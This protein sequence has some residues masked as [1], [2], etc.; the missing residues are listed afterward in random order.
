MIALG[1]LFNTSA[2]H[3][4]FA[5]TDYTQ[6]KVFIFE[7]DSIVWEHAA[8]NSNDLWVL[9][10]GNILFTTGKGVLEMTRKND[11]VFR[12]ESS[13]E[14]YACQ[15]LKNGNTFIG[16]CNNG[17]LLEISPSGKI[18]FQLKILPDSMK[19]GGHGFMRNA[20]K[21][22]NG[23]YLVTL[24][25]QKVVREYTPKGKVVWEVKAP[26]GPH[27]VV[28]LPNGNTLVS[29]GDATKDPH[30]C[31]FDKDGNLVWD[32]SNA[33]LP[34]QPFRFLGGM[35]RFPNG[36]TLV[37]NWLGHK[38]FGMAPHII[39]LTPDKKIVWTFGGHPRIKTISSFVD[40]DVPA[41]PLKAEVL[42]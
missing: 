6:G 26:G 28:R 39:E 18:V 11:T 8:P 35:Q 1:F 27:S 9:P 19:T 15:R 7:K 4:S 12:Y 34:G 32:V 38:Q 40:L 5:C 13:S 33:D 41:D 3:R 10:N 37:C 36:N 31:E 17:R 42:H 2:Q 29:D 23:N 25:K 22:D 30:V 20:R 24:F 21:L 16:E 14:I